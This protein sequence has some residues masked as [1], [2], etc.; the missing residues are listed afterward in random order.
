M[1]AGLI[2]CKRRNP[3]WM[4]RSIRIV[5][6]FN[7]FGIDHNLAGLRPQRVRFRISSEVRKRCKAGFC[8]ILRVEVNTILHEISKSRQLR[9]LRCPSG[10][11]LFVEPLNPPRFIQTLGKSVSQSQA[12]GEFRINLIVASCFSDGIDHLTHEDDAVVGRRSNR[13]N[14]VSLQGR[15]RRQNDVCMTCRRAPEGIRDN[16]RFRTAPGRFECSCIR[17]MRKGIPAR[18]EDQA[19][20][21]IFNA[22]AVPIN[23]FARAGKYVSH[24]RHRNG[25]AALPGYGGLPNCL[26]T[27][28]NLSQNGTFANRP[29]AAF[30]VI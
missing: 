1:H 24:T 9:I 18:P 5:K 15:R 23:H 17:M 13:R 3:R 11:G 28:R 6:R 20:I 4:C 19:D 26:W 14:V 10:S 29:A 27:S 8:R 7:A 2:R 16:H 22:A 12:F 25:T 30:I 21:G